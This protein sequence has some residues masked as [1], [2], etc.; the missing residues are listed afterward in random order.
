VVQY[1]LEDT[2]KLPFSIAQYA[3][4]FI[5]RDGHPVLR[6]DVTGRVANRVGN[7]YDLIALYKEFGRILPMAITVAGTA[8]R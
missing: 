2:P 4:W 1:W 3:F 8:L 7:V 6:L 5:V